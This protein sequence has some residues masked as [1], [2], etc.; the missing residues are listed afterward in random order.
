MK[1]IMHCLIIFLFHF[2]LYADNYA[3][4][5]IN[6]KDFIPFDLISLHDRKTYLGYVTFKNGKI[7]CGYGGGIQACLLDSYK[8]N[9]IGVEIYIERT[10][11]TNIN[12]TN[13]KYRIWLFPVKYKVFISYEEIQKTFEMD[14]VGTILVDITQ[15]YPTTCQAII[16]DNLNIRNLPSLSGKRIGMLQKGTEV[17]LYEQSTNRDEIDGEKNFWYKVKNDNE[18]YGW[19]Y[20]GYAR[21]FFEDLNLGYTDKEKIL[22]SIKD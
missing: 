12:D 17:T 4:F 21:I 1:K 10:I 14:S 5:D 2:F 6:K 9:E 13:F 7:S 8:Y 16:I 18:T 15:T 20:G 11:F 22:E 19:I 3:V